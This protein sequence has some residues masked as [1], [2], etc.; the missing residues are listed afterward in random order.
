[1]SI[2][3]RVST[4]SDA[5]LKNGRRASWWQ[6]VKRLLPLL[7]AGALIVAL[8][9][10]IINATN[11]YGADWPTHLWFLRH[12][13]DSLLHDH[14]PSL[15]AHGNDG[16]FY[17]F[18]AF[19]GG[20]LFAIGGLV[21]VALGGAGRHGYVVVWVLPYFLAYGGWVWLGKMAGLGRWAV[22]APPVL[23]L[24]SPYLVT[25][26]Y[27]RGDW[28]EFVALCSIPMLVASTLSVLFA[29]GLRVW[30][31]VALVLAAIL[32]TGSHNLTLLWG[33]TL[34]A[35]LGLV[36]YVCSPQIRRR[37]TGRGVARVA[38]L[39]VPAVLV[40]AWFLAP[41]LVY[42]SRTVIAG[43][44]YAEARHT[45]AHTMEIIDQ[46]IFGFRRYNVTQYDLTLPVLAMAW[47]V[48]MAALTLRR[49]WRTSWML[50][51]VSL[52]VLI[53]LLVTM[54]THGSLILHLPKPYV[55]IQYT[56]RLENYILLAV[57]GGVLVGL[58]LV[59]EAGR[60][61]RRLAWASLAA[62]VAISAAGA[63]RQIDIPPFEPVAQV[64]LWDARILS[65]GDYAD[66]TPPEVPLGN[67]NVLFF[68]AETIRHDRIS[69]IVGAQPGEVVDTNLVV[70]P[71]LI[72]ISG[73]RMIGNRVVRIGD[74]VQPRAV[75]RVDPKA[76]PGA[77]PIT[78]RGARPWPV[79]VGQILSLLGVLG[80]AANVLL[81]RPWRRRQRLPG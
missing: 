72:H 8:T 10:P 2:A 9:W 43:I 62:V 19:Y 3:Q 46:P 15:F 49:T 67:R 56:F 57:A 59:N 66:G 68:R 27:A 24:T 5:E 39:F 13:G 64:P 31:A 78:V 81:R 6:R 18:F 37:V 41:E 55:M 7:C 50:L 44:N 53:A 29:D 71:A 33:S 4:G 52:G 70:M 35:A 28:P 34:L 79:V 77:A 1:M 21:V 17:P 26:V 65:V 60:W 36:L 25:L 47:A 20:T 16:A 42:H 80:L 48:S 73:A 14:R 75:L 58:V 54:L 45:V 51:F 38:G 30:P 32:F 74:F 63:L 11:N 76:I 40:N 61:M 69:S 12:Q 23:F 22:H